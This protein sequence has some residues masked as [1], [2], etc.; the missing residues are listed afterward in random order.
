MPG[1]VAAD[2][3]FADTAWERAAR[4]HG[5]DP[6]LLYSLALVESRRH[7]GAGQIAP[8][9]WVIRTPTGGYWFNSRASAERGLAAVL[10]K[11]PAKRVD[12][13]AAQ[14][15]VGWHRD[16]F[17]KPSQLLDLEY[18]L[19][20]AA[21]ILAEAIHSTADTVVGVGRYH[22][23]A[24]APR[25]RRY[26]QRVWWTYRAITFGSPDPR[27]R[28]ALASETEIAPLAARLSAR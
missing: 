14:V 24:S 2:L 3:D 12:V 7:M 20:V 8:W 11:W 19:N 5:I 28:Y 17:G 16:R 1:A 18:N 15:N 13:G 23:W 10:A 27:S 22:H 21:G 25:A 9:P 4:P 26:G 6:A